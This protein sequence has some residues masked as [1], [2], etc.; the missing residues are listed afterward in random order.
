[1]THLQVAEITTKKG[2]DMTFKQFTGEYNRLI[3]K[4][5]KATDIDCENTITEYRTDKDD[6][7]KTIER[8]DNIKSA[9][10]NQCSGIEAKTTLIK[11]NF[12]IVMLTV[13]TDKKS[14]KKIKGTSFHQV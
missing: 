14:R 4:T 9:E 3:K 12:I 6:E 11:D 13:G 8:I 5:T 10:F 2:K 7:Y 1:M